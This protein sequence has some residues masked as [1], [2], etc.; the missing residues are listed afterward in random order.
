MPDATAN[1]KAKVTARNI[2]RP[3][4]G[5]MLKSLRRASKARRANVT[6]LHI[7]VLTN[8]VKAYSLKAK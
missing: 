4:K 5:S 2:A 7:P 3:A 6:N 1:V 8:K